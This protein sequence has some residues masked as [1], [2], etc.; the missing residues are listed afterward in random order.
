MEMK[1]TLNKIV[2]CSNLILGVFLYFILFIPQKIF[3]STEK[4]LK[5]YN[6]IKNI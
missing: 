3:N 1:R 2:V 6:Q 5:N 4:F